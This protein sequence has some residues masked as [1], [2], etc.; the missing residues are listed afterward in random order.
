MSNL[1]TNINNIPAIPNESTSLKKLVAS[2]FI[3]VGVVLGSS[4]AISTNTA[5]NNTI[6]FDQ[7]SVNNDIKSNDIYHQESQRYNTSN[8]NPAKYFTNQI[9]IDMEVINM[10][11]QEFGKI[12]SDIAHLIKNTDVIS[13]KMDALPTKEWVANQINDNIIANYKKTITNLKWFVGIFVTLVGIAVPVILKM[14]F[15]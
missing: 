3:G 5:S 2:V 11:A 13:A 4:P 12:Q 15:K 10:D 14:F 9:Y 6:I 7:S 8:D 1:Q